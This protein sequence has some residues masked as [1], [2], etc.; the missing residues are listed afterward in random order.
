MNHTTGIIGQKNELEAEASSGIMRTIFICIILTYACY[1]F[2]SDSEELVLNPIER[3]INYVKKVVKNPLNID[4]IDQENEEL[5]QNKLKDEDDNKFWS[6]CFAGKKEKKED[7]S[8]QM[9]TRVLENSLRKICNLLV[10]G[11]GEAGKDIIIHNI[12]KKDDIDTM[13]K[14]KKV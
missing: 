1:L 7:I 3:M 8:K 2:S 11:V 4:D 6:F 14:G 10:I 5:D 9:E 12:Q 13:L